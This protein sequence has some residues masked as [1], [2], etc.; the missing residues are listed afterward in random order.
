MGPGRRKVHAVRAL[1]LDGVAQEDAK[2]DAAP[3]MAN[4][5][6]TGNLSVGKS[7]WTAVGLWNDCI[8]SYPQPGFPGVRKAP[9]ARS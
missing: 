2:G 5:L 6:T 3:L 4:R 9:V 1:G 8:S 7:G